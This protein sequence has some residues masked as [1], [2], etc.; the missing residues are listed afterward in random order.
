MLPSLRFLFEI[1]VSMHFLLEML[2]SLHCPLEV[3]PQRMA[4]F[5]SSVP[6]SSAA[7]EVETDFA[8]NREAS[9]ADT[10]P[11][12][13]VDEADLVPYEDEMFELGDDDRRP[14]SPPVKY[15]FY[16]FCDRSSR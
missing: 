4:R 2:G 10:S 16:F 9:L 7:R 6:T 14:C 3:L 15:F 8:Q 5:Q 12:T 13:G 1:L 11:I